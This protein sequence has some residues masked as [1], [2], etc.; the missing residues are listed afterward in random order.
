MLLRITSRPRARRGALA[1]CLA[2]GIACGSAAVRAQTPALQLKIATVAPEGTTWMQ[3]MRE[4]DAAVRKE[5]GNAV[6]FKIYAGG[7]QGDEMVVLRKVRSGQLHGGGLTGRGLGSIAP[8]LRVMELPFLISSYA[9]VDQ[10]RSTLNPRFEAI[11]HDAGYTVLGWADVGFVYVFSR[12]PIPDQAS[13][14]T[15]KMWLWEGDPLAEALFRAV[16]IVP[17]PLAITDVMTS[18]QTRLVDG[19]YSSPLGCLSLQWFSRVAYYT[20]MPLTFATGAVVV[21]N[22]AWESV[23]AQHRATVQRICAEKLAAL[24]GRARQED[25]EALV[26]IEKNGVRKVPVSAAERARFEAIGRSVWQ[27]ETGKLYAQDLLDAVLAAVQAT[28]AAAPAAAP[29]PTPGT[30]SK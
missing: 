14:K 22:A 9:Q 2:A 7:V 5:T 21:S 8:A 6:G 27:E 13:L 29:A 3:V 16:G 19:V 4:I 10:V 15:A 12:Q 28:P 18:L 1:L 25:A 20:D 23:P 17:V 11:V 24:S 26:Q 30:K